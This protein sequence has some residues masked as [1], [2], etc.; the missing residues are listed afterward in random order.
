MFQLQIVIQLSG[1]FRREA[2]GFLLVDQVCHT[3]FGRL[4]G[5]ERDHITRTRPRRNKI[6]DFFVGSCHWHTVHLRQIS[7]QE[8][9]RGRYENQH[10]TLGI[11]RGE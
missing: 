10:L 6:D 8:T 2:G 4:G 1:F 7:Y 3:R 11:R 5:L 9:C